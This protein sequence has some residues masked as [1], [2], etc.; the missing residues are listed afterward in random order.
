MS[1]RGGRFSSLWSCVE[2]RLE[3]AFKAPRPRPAPP[4]GNPNPPAPRGRCRGGNRVQRSVG[5]R[6][7]GR[8]AAAARPERPRRGGLG[9]V[10]PPQRAPAGQAGAAGALHG[11]RR[12]LRGSGGLRGRSGGVFGRP[13]DPHCAVNTPWQ[14]VFLYGTPHIRGLTATGLT[15][16]QP[17]APRNL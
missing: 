12:H 14:L 13:Q 2:M 8:A 1:R 11:P 16:T 3:S 15:S 6:R 10:Y 9:G 5:D 4:G 17:T 7:F